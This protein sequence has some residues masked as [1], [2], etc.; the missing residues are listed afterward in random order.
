M[1]IYVDFTIITDYSHPSTLF[2]YKRILVNT[3]SIPSDII[4]VELYI[5]LWKMFL[6]YLINMKD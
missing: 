1:F 4:T 2:H 3:A 5:V 6:I